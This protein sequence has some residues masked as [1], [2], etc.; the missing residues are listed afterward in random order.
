MQPYHSG[1]KCRLAIT[2]KNE[3]KPYYQVGTSCAFTFTT[4][5]SLCTVARKGTTGLV[6]GGTP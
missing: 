1:K 6:S 5:A 4:G 3:R 2:K